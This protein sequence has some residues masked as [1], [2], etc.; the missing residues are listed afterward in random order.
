MQRDE[1]IILQG[2]LD[3]VT[4]ALRKQP[5][6]CIAAQNYECNDRGYGR[7][8]GYEVYDG[9]PEPHLASYWILNF[10]SGSTEMAAG[11]AVEGDTSGATGI[12]LEDAT[13]SSGTY[14]GG[15]AAGFVVLYNVDGTFEDN[16]GL[17]VSAANVA[18]ADGA[19][20][21][22]AA[23]NDA[24]DN[25]YLQAAIEARRAAI[26]APTGSGGILGVTTFG[27]AAYCWRNNAGGTAATM[28]KSTAAG[29]VAQSFGTLLDF[30]SG[31]TYQI[32][33][34]DTITGAT[35]TQTATVERVV[36]QSG[37][38]GAGDAAGYLVLSS[39]SGAFAAENLDVGGN[40]NVATIAGNSSA[41]TLPAGGT[42]RAIEH[43]FFGT[44]NLKRLYFVNTV[45]YAHEWDGTVLVPIKVPGLTVSTDKPV[46]VGEH[47]NH[48][49]LAYPGGSVL[50]SGT[51]LPLSYITTNGAGEFG[52]GEDITGLI[53][54]T[55]KATVVAG[56]NKLGYLTGNDSTDFVFD[57]ISEESGAVTD[58]MQ[59]IGDIR[60]L[61]DIGVRALATAQEYGDWS[62]GTDTKFVEPLIKTKR[63]GGVSPVAACRVRAKNQYRLF[64]NDKTVLSV[65]YGRAQP[66]SMT[67]VLDFTPTC[68][69]SGE[70]ASGDE[71]I[72]AGSSDGKVYRMDV[73]ASADGEQI[74]AYIVLAFSNQRTPNYEKRYHRALVSVANGGPSLTL[75]HSANFAYGDLNLPAGLET[76]LSLPGSGGFWDIF[77]WD[78]FNWDSASEAEGYVEL[79]AIGKNIS[80]AIAHVSTYEEPHT[81]TSITINWTPRR[82]LR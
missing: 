76:D 55:R 24:T 80:N 26:A 75:T 20:I 14:G 4:P 44:S 19:S 39:Q 29:W 51:G 5:G 23:E 28:F 74:E 58:T 60:Y 63:K 82:K 41:I 21:Q 72:L 59:A 81:I 17:E 62:I 15:D 79:N 56:R 40:A 3:L 50:F 13:V 61:D 46:Y 6:F 68:V 32:A 34:G 43:N 45:G 71:I 42:Y 48:L 73:G 1:T 38:W 8:D 33:E 16:E 66:E 36:V 47:S 35:S 9:R 78:Q 70:Q 65:Y 57:Y 10:D 7:I 53:S 67:L 11:D 25:A 12:V 77:I 64:Y 27:G 18:T 2:G 37:T 30:T 52:L 54:R 69:F 31:G 22:R 49:L